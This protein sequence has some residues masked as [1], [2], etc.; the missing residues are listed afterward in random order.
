VDTLAIDSSTTYFKPLNLSEITQKGYKIQ[1]MDDD[2]DDDS[3][4]THHTLCIVNGISIIPFWV[5]VI[6]HPVKKSYLK[7]CISKQ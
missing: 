1:S 7:P 6:F 3:L 5:R 2:D 4:C